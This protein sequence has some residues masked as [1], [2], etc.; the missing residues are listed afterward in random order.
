MLGQYV[1]DIPS[2]FKRTVENLVRRRPKGEPENVFEDTP[3]PY[4]RNPV[5]DVDLE[6]D[7]CKNKLPIC[8]I[9]GL[10]ITYG[11]KTECPHCQQPASY[12]LFIQYLQ[13]NTACPLCEQNVDIHDVISPPESRI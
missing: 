3:C 2:K 9:S 8:I 1:D 11:D 5:P 4:C 12:S 10:H 7:S 13:T 6:C